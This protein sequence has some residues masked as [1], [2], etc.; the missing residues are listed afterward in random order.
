MDE[1]V[2]SK[3]LAILNSLIPESSKPI[4]PWQF[5]TA[6]H[7]GPGQYAFDGDWAD[8]S[9]P[10]YC[11]AGKTIFL[12]AKAEVSA[13][14]P[15]KDTYLAVGFDE[16]EGMLSVNGRP[17]CGLDRHHGRA[18]VPGTGQWDLELEFFSVPSVY[19]K[20]WNANL[21]GLFDGARLL[22]V[23]RDIEG[24]YYDIRVAAEVTAA[25]SDE[26]RKAML[27][28]AVEQAL[29]AV[30]L[31]LPRQRLLEEAAEARKALAG[32]VE[33]IGLDPEAG[34]LFLAG[35]SHIDT[36]WLWPLRETIRK[37]GRT[38]ST[39]LRL[40]DRYPEFHFSCSQPQLYQY[41]KDHYPAVY[42][43]IK[44]RVKEGRWETQG[45]MWVESDCNVTS[46]ESLIRQVLHGVR[47]FAAEFGTRPRS[48][49]L[50]D[51]FGYP[52]SLPEI[53]RGCGLDYFFTCKLHW[54]AQNPFPM[55]LFRWRGLDGTEIIAHVP[56]HP[57]YYNNQA[58]AGELL[59]SW[60]NYR[61]K[62]EYGEVLVPFGHGDGGGGVTEEMMEQVIRFARYPGMPRVRGGPSDRYF[63]DLVAQAPPLPV[64]DGELYL[65]THRGTYTT[66]GEA[67][68]AN[69][70]MELLLREAEVFGSLARI[71]GGSVDTRPLE[72]AWK[73]VLLLQFH[74]ILPGS[75]IGM[76]YKEAAADYASSRLGVEGVLGS[77]LRSLSG[78]KGDEGAAGEAVCV[79]NS[80]S[81]RR[82]DL[83]VATVAD[84]GG[85]FAVESPSGKVS[86][87]QVLA[88][89]AGKATI[90]FTAEGVPPMG[91]AGY[92]VVAARAKAV[93]SLSASR[94]KIESNLYLI[95]LN[96]NGG[97]TRLLDKRQGREVV[98]RGAVAN[99]LQLF[100]D[101]PENE[102]AW[103]VH[104]TFDKRRYP[105]DGPTE[106]TVA[107]SGPL[108]AV[109]RVK[110]AHRRSTFIQDVIV[111]GDCPRIDFVTQADWREKQTV[112]KVAFPVDIRA[113][114]A[115][116]EVQFGAV[117]RP[118]HRNTSWD[119]S[120]FEVCGH[121]WA[122]L[123][124]G[125]Y[126]VSLLNDCKY[127]HDSLGN[128][129]R[130][131]LLRGTILPDPDADQGPCEIIYSL[132][133]HQGDWREGQTVLRAWEI[134]APLRSVSLAGGAALSGGSLLCLE[135]AAAIVEAFKPAEDGRG[136]IL[137]L[138]EPH[139]AR[140][141][142]NVRLAGP[143]GQVVECNQIEEDIAPV[144]VQAERFS[145]S[146]LPFQIRAF[147][148]LF[149]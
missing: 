23:N 88:R 142:V 50:P 135:G 21:R 6:A 120:K 100:Q 7:L 126:G 132:L 57:R 71:A 29:L 3:R 15:L 27:S 113:T 96:E 147:R 24:L 81:W 41:T 72:A 136:Y 85:E 122:D 130:L 93:S 36:A 37:C 79:F 70:K 109:V 138:Y 91:F 75:S 65:E 31:T 66:H 19:S 114:R 92:K 58:A 143:A 46:G 102:D 110:R 4:G 20:P 118:T 82:N 139:G 49:W 68:R 77:A 131:T 146:I 87:A 115:T 64:W 22:T 123:S 62:A 26:R 73:T 86:A 74:D 105:F 78:S 18:L 137:R 104:A 43:E 108:R 48:C 103:N 44:K 51:V 39:A 128:V 112:L 95:E 119:A 145:F 32:A 127:G 107:E 80:L 61:Q 33:S 16:M 38:F 14:V 12:R 30:D 121:R 134:N 54:Q 116:Y 83:A 144:A 67:K 89:S 149:Q 117:E 60:S 10:V 140:G 69:R 129:M 55:S 94:G 34:K 99:D 17:W 47:F 35:H 125:G 98:P 124:E 59:T 101:G 56:K 84:R 45:G 1:R 13:D 2:I 8:A 97:I 133:P 106:T 25:I 28:S 5:R 141:A 52:A 90:A 76:V 40:M 63:D 53:L 148:I 42:E 111:Y 9:L 11:Q